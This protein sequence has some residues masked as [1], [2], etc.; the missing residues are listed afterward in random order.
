MARKFQNLVI[1]PGT[2]RSVPYAG[3]TIR[4][5]PSTEASPIAPVYSN[6]SADPETLIPQPFL[7]NSIGMLEFY[8]PDGRY[9]IYIEAGIEGEPGFVKLKWEDVYIFDPTVAA[10][11][12]TDVSAGRYVVTQ[13]SAQLPN[14]IVIPILRGSADRVPSFAAIYDNEF[15]SGSSAWGMYS[16]DGP[17]ITYFFIDQSMLELR[18]IDSNA[19]FG[20]DRTTFSELHSSYNLTSSISIGG[21]AGMDGGELSGEKSFVGLGIRSQ[22]DNVLAIGLISGSEGIR[23]CYG[24]LNAGGINSFEEHQ[25]IGSNHGYFRIAK[26]N[27]VYFFDWSSN[28]HSWIT[29]KSI[30]DPLFSTSS[31]KTAGI[32]ASASVSPQGNF[33]SHTDFVRYKAL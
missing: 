21:F 19:L 13:S 10:T 16:G 8:A 20:F 18:C 14:A 17:G 1:R 22:S 30:A 2:G 12:T 33:T 3:V 5:Y 23:V 11:T 26:R 28:G 4:E 29:V 6:S 27:A 31:I 32:Y 9:D 24:D 7:S 15:E 25:L